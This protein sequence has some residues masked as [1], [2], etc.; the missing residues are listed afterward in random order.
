MANCWGNIGG[1][2]HVIVNGEGESSVA[3]CGVTGIEDA[4]QPTAL[5]LKC[6]NILPELGEDTAREI[7]AERPGV[8]PDTLK[9]ARS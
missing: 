8:N 6:E 9:G 2:A 4:G 3:L 1:T 7:M 5:C